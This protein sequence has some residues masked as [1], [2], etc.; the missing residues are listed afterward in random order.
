MKDMQVGITISLQKLKF[1]ENMHSYV[2]SFVAAIDYIHI[3]IQ[4]QY[5]LI[6]RTKEKKKRKH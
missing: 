6:S 3:I 5:A 4:K 1:I 2:Y